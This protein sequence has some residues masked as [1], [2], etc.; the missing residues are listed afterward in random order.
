MFARV[1]IITETNSRAVKIPVSA[2]ISRNDENYI[3]VAEVVVDD[4]DDDNKNETDDDVIEPVKYIAKRINV[5]PGIHIDGILEI[6][7]GLNAGDDVIIRGHSLLDD[8]AR[9]NIVE[10]VAPLSN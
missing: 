1:R 8:G 9:I 3:F 2:L 7:H 5:V 4:K 10:R 6:L